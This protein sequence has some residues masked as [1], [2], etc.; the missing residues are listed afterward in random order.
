M[1]HARSI[2]ISGIGI[3]GAT[4]A[5]WLGKYG[6]TPTL[7]EC[8]P[9]FRDGGYVV[10][11]WGRGYDI[12]ERMGLVP[13]LKDEG[14]DI[15]EL[16]IVDAR[17]RRISG[18]GV[19]V[20]RKLTAGRYVSI[21]RSGL[22]QLIYHAVGNN[23]ETI[24]GDTITHIVQDDAG[25]YVEFERSP[26]R[27]FDIVIG[28]DGLHSAVRRIIFA[29][30]DRFEKYL[31]YYVAAF[32]VD[33]YPYR[34]ES[35]Y[36]SYCL[37]GKQVARFAMRDG[38]TLF[39][40]VFASDRR[41]RLH[42]LAAQKAVLHG[43]FAGAGWECPLILAAMDDCN[44]I[45]FDSASQIRMDAWSRGRV[46]LI[47][48]AAFC[49]SLL[50]GQGAALAMIAAYVLAGE[51]SGAEPAPEPAFRRY[52]QRLRPFMT[53][54]QKAAERFAGSFAPKTR[55]GLLLRNQITRALALPYVADIALGPIVHDRL[56]LPEYPAAR[57]SS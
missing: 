36:V 34:D 10:D 5:Y 56:D 54:K 40:F 50:A 53:E 9:R 7:V 2:L 47:G 28:A 33:D 8:A 24:F 29:N 17:G 55:F 42:D 20:F 45:Y 41:A 57:L 48:D 14:Y 46:A 23:V 4:M 13:G 39:L 32:K 1:A 3:A 22:A 35:I 51:L 43:E 30:E 44:E 37:P 18:F 11:F 27:R 52:E 16:R 49:P 6:F 21:A 19:E 12:A 31:G 26:A 38:R 25:A 15:R